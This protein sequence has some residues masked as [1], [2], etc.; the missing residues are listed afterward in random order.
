MQVLDV[1]TEVIFALEAI[2]RHQLH[3]TSRFL[4][5]FCIITHGLIVEHEGIVI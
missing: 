3:Q 5:L 4:H 2:F 1:D